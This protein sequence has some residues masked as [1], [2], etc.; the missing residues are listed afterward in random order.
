MLGLRCVE[1]FSS[2]CEEVDRH[3][4]DGTGRCWNLEI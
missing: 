2:V 3:D 1:L 4:V